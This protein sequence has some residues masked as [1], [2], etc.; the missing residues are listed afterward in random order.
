MEKDKYDVLY[1]NIIQLLNDI[2]LTN[3]PNA[4]SGTLRKHPI[5][6]KWLTQH[7]K[8]IIISIESKLS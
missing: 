6:K 5:I 2:K 7:Q 3:G 8:S 1:S 4:V